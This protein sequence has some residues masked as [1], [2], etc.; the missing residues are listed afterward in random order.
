MMDR[1]FV[2]LG[3]S[4]VSL[5]C[6]NI[7]SASDQVPSEGG[8]DDPQKFGVEGNA[9]DE[10]IVTAQKRDESVN[11]VP[12]SISAVSGKQLTEAGIN[13]LQDL[14]KIVPGFNYTESAFGTPVYT[15]RGVG[16]YE[17]SIGAKPTVSVYVDK[18]IC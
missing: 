2:S 5:C 14:V 12:M 10:I 16:F 8:A 4:V 9:L 13:G 1:V 18:R 7:A 15:L 17:T 11:E 3:V 6:A